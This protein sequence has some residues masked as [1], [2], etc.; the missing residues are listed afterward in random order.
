MHKAK[1]AP[2]IAHMGADD[3]PALW[4]L[5]QAAF[6]PGFQASVAIMAERVRRGHVFLGARLGERLVGAV[7]YVLT[8]LDPH[9]AEAFPR[10]FAEYSST[11][12]SA[13]P[14]SAYVYSLGVHPDFR[15]TRVV[16]QLIEAGVASIVRS[17]CRYITCDGPCNAYAGTADG[18]IACNDRF[19]RAIDQWRETGMKPPERHL[20]LDPVLRFYKQVLRCEFLYLKPAFL[21]GDS[22]SG[23]HRVILLK[24]LPEAG[25][26][27]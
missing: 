16:L 1:P 3:I 25:A 23:G 2:T 12:S 24:R 9:D 18:S 7:C 5:E 19:R 15:A 6:P 22:A 4:E 8:K 21:P 20:L 27:P 17:G 10:T 11:V 13:P 26:I 14:L